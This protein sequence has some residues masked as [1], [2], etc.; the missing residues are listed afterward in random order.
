MTLGRRRVVRVPASTA[1]LGPGFDV[2]AAALALHLEVEVVETGTTGAVAVETDLDL[3]T[4]STNL[5][6]RAFERLHSVEGLTF[7]IQSRIPLSGGLGSSAAAI[8]AGLM[9]ADHMFE[10]DADVRALATELEGHP[11]NVAAA[12]DGGFVIC[13]GGDTRRFEVPFG[14]EAVLV[15]PETP[16]RTEEARA[17][18]PELVPLADAVFNVGQASLL[19]LGLATGDWETVAAGLHDRLHQPYRAHLYPRSASLLERATELGALGAT[20]SGAG[21]TVLVWSHLEQTGALVERLG[22]ETGEWARVLR[23]PF[24]SQGADVRGL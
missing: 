9:A 24:E 1:N 3:P 6:V 19:T 16:V 8:V 23:V 22:R 7:R 21:P 12:L 13:A 10:L 2:M 11:D 18:L 4:D 17:A 20:I 5:V 14:L 15:V